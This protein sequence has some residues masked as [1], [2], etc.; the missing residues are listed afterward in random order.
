MLRSLKIGKKG[1]Q[2]RESDE[3]AVVRWENLG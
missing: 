3:C 2:E 1:E